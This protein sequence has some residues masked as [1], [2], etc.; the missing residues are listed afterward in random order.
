MNGQKNFIT[1]F[2][3]MIDRH[4]AE[5]RAAVQGPA[6]PKS[7]H[8]LRWLGRQMV[9]NVGTVLIVV[10]LLL[11]VPSLAAPLRKPSSS[12]TS[13]VSYQ[14]RLADSAGEP[15]TGDFGMEFRIYDV[16]TGGTPLWTELWTGANAVGVADGLFS[17]ML[18]SINNTLASSIE[19]EDELYLGITVDTDPEMVPRVQLSSVP[20]AMQAVSLV[21]EH[22]YYFHGSLATSSEWMADATWN[23]NYPR[24]CEAIGK[25]YVRSEQLQYHFQPERG[26][27]Y[28]Y[29]G[30]YYSGTRYCEADTHI[31]GNGTAG[32]PYNVWRYSGECGCCPHDHGWGFEASA[33]IWCR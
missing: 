24:F 10:V 2:G 8:W 27:G 3:E 14:G 16:S 7:R 17:V 23:S 4:R 5:R 22:P 1:R 19:G 21:G 12:S 11:T 29:S 25:T 18:G 32:W 30:W 6:R 33:I 28:F 9:P 20:F 13:V 26:N 15:V 31:W